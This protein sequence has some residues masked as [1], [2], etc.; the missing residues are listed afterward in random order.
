MSAL[1]TAGAGAG[2]LAYYGATGR[3]PGLGSYLTGAFGGVGAGALLHAAQ[4]EPVISAAPARAAAAAPAQAAALAPAVKG[5]AEAEEI[6]IGAFVPKTIPAVLP[7]S[8]AVG[9][10]GGAVNTAYNVGMGGSLSS[11]LASKLPA[12]SLAA[13]TLGGVGAAGKAVGTVAGKA[14][15]P[16]NVAINGYQAAGQAFIDPATGKLSRNVGANVAGHAEKTLSDVGDSVLRGGVA[17]LTNMPATASA[18]GR[19]AWDTYT[20]EH[21]QAD[22]DQ[23]FK[24]R[25]GKTLAATN[26]AIS[27][28]DT[29]PNRMRLRDYL[30][31]NM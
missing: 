10:A 13:K 20:T 21:S 16:L 2:G 26:Q 5:L 3:K 28:G 6:P 4:H 27:A 8:R 23:S 19:A 25:I 24:D 17:G 22:K 18:L 29:S 30:M 31:R 15:L 7:G 12:G 9:V 14:L 1:A 11:W